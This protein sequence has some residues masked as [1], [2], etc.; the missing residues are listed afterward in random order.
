MP[1]TGLATLVQTLALVAGD[2]LV[3]QP[4]LR[5]RVVQVVVD[6]VVAERRTGHA[7]A[8]ECVDR[9]AERRRKALGA[10]FVR[11]A[12]ERRRRLQLLLDPVQPCGDQRRKSEIGIDVAAGDAGLDALR[13]P[14]PDDAET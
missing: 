12:L 3:E 6:D 11:V 7:A 1:M 8:F 14:A 13:R 9:L 4:L 2:G 5:P 10:G